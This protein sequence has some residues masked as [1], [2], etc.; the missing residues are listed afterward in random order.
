M[1]RSRNGALAAALIATAVLGSRIGAAMPA[2][3]VERPDTAVST[4]ERFRLV[5]G[6]SSCVVVKSAAAGDRPAGLS[7]GQDCDEVMP[8]LSGVRFWREEAD[9][10]VLFGSVGGG[11]MAAFAQ[12]DGA[13]YESFAPRRPLMAPAL[14]PED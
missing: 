3:T 6:D 2:A 10:S 7:A 14:V 4:S 1:N 9:G 5:S 11:A 8:R 12:A 13:G